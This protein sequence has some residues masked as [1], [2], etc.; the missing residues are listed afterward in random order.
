MSQLS[1]TRDPFAPIAFIVNALT[2]LYVL[3]I[4]GIGLATAIGSGSI[5]A[6]GRDTAACIDSDGNGV[7]LL[8]RASF[9]VIPHSAPGVRSDAFG[10]ADKFDICASHPGVGLRLVASLPGMVSLLFVLGFLAVTI[11]LIRLARRNGLFT[12]AVARRVTGLG[13]YLLVGTLVSTAGSA[14]GRALFL[15]GLSSG[16]GWISPWNVTEFSVPTIVAGFG[17]LTF[18]RVME[19]AVRMQNEIDATV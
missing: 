11:G 17:V 15:H 18:G 12:S 19:L 1:A 8:P 2:A 14:L 3:A 16:T 7:P 9:N 6:F 5:F 4:V 13:G 10:H